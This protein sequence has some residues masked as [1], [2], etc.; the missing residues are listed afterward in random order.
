MILFRPHP[1]EAR[2]ALSKDEG[3]P[4][5][6]DALLRSAPQHEAVEKVPAGSIHFDSRRIDLERA[7][8]DFAAI[9][10]VDFELIEHAI[11]DMQ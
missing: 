4:M 9:V 5:L 1:E 6:R 10:F 8:F 11:D 7:D 3:G 2:S